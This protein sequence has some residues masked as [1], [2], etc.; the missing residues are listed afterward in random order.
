ML[1]AASVV[2]FKDCYVQLFLLLID[3]CVQLFLC[4]LWTGYFCGLL[5]AAIFVLLVVIMHS[6]AQA[7]PCSV[8]A[9]APNCMC[10]VIKLFSGSFM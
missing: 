3:S 1:C 7:S 5:C 8:F 10:D 9:N 2:L 4:Y 6:A